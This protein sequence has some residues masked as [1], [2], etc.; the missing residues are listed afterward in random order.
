[1]LMHL[2]SGDRGGPE[3]TL[4]ARSHTPRTLRTGLDLRPTNTPWAAPADIPDAPAPVAF[5]PGDPRSLPRCTRHAPHNESRPD[6]RSPYIRATAVLPWLLQ[7]PHCR[8][9]LLRDA[10]N[11]ALERRGVEHERSEPENCC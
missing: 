2:H 10:V 7:P 8:V 5:A 9:C 3:T 4:A 1:H 6:G 11:D